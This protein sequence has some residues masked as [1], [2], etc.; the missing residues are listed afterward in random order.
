MQEA[1]LW[2]YCSNLHDVLMRSL[3][4]QECTLENLLQISSE[5]R[6]ILASLSSFSEAA[7]IPSFN[8]PTGVF[9]APLNNGQAL[10]PGLKC[11]IKMLDERFPSFGM[12][13][14]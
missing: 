10:A 5:W 12:H 11:Y 8:N 14:A 2:R 4:F 13:L 9:A 6:A 7:F 1:G 3:H